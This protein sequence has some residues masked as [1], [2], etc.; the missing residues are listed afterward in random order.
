[1]LFSTKLVALPT[2]I[3]YTSILA[4]PLDSIY[5]EEGK[6]ALKRQDGGDDIETLAQLDPIRTGKGFAFV[7]VAYIKDSSSCRLCRQLRQPSHCYLYDN[8]HRR[9]SH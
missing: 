2:F 1:M 5:A 3:W 9:Q 7:C 4:S 6:K 8:Q